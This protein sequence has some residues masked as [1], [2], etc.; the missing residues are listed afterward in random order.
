MLRAAVRRESNVNEQLVDPTPDGLL[1]HKFFDSEKNKLCCKRNNLFIPFANTV[2]TIYGLLV[3]FSKMVK[4]GRNR[5]NLFSKTT[6]VLLV[7][8]IEVFALEFNKVKNSSTGAQ[9][10][11]SSMKKSV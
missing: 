1:Q 6:E 5:E 11:F 8:K 4:T 7:L 10:D 2:Q 9:L 3:Y